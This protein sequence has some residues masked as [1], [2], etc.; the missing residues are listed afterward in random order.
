MVFTIWSFEKLGRVYF[1]T[2]F[3]I[4]TLYVVDGILTTVRSAMLY[5]LKSWVVKSQHDDKI[6]VVEM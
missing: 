6:S 2:T 5:G 4:F 1:I 3:S